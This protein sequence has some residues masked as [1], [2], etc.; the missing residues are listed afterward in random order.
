M[1]VTSRGRVTVRLVRVQLLGD[2]VGTGLVNLEVS[3]KG[4]VAKGEGDHRLVD[5]GLDLDVIDDGADGVRG[6]LGDDR[7]GDL[8]GLAGVGV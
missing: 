3:E 8:P 5:I 2:G 4:G 6:A 7:G 1:D